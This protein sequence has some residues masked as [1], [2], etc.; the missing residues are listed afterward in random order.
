[1]SRGWED[2][3]IGFG[4]FGF[5][6]SKWVGRSAVYEGRYIGEA[7]DS[8]GDLFCRVDVVYWEFLVG[9][10]VVVSMWYDGYYCYGYYE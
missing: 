10:G 7:D 2:V 6:V 4:I 9:A 1:M 8:L 3:R 5:F